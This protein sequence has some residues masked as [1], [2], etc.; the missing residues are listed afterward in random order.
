MTFGART[1]TETAAT[2]QSP[3]PNDGSFIPI[4]ARQ[5]TNSLFAQ[6]QFTLRDRFDFSYGGRIDSVE[7]GQTFATW[8]TTA[9][10][11]IDETGTKFH[12]SV[13]TGAKVATLYQRFSQYG[14]PSLQPEQSVGFDAGVDQK[15]F[16]DRLT[17]S[18]T[19]FDNRYRNLIDFAAAPSCT[20]LQLASA[21]GCYY[22]VGRAET[23][24]VETAADV[25][26]VP[27][28]WRARASYT[29][30]IARDLVTDTTLLQRPRDKATLSL[31]LYGLSQARS[32]DPV[33]A[34]QQPL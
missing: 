8:R 23:K 6:H 28:E 26:L 21:G 31:D 32:R 10:Y 11:R 9:A 29:F 14:D 3:N 25:I 22:N 2:S 13:G 12:A 15:L 24:G 7:S 5:T 4:D 20:P 1:E 17:A 30:M 34:G 27:D 19:A 16:D 18:V 33:D